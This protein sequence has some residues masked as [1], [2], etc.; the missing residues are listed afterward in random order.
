MLGVGFGEVILLPAEQ[1]DEDRPDIG[2][3]V[4][5]VVQKRVEAFLMRADVAVDNDAVLDQHRRGDHEPDR[6]DK[7]EPFVVRLDGGAGL[8]VARHYPVVG[9]R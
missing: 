8:W 6:L 9:Q 4:F 3:G 2:D 7:A 5:V 1:L